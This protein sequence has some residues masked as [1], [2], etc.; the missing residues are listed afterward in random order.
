[1]LS[2]YFQWW[3]LSKSI[4]QS[5]TLTP[6][7]SHFVKELPNGIDGP[8]LTILDKHKNLTNQYEIW[9]ILGFIAERV[10]YFSFWK[11]RTSLPFDWNPIN[12]LHLQY[13]GCPGCAYESFQTQMLDWGRSP[14]LIFCVSASLEAHNSLHLSPWNICS[15]F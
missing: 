1:M 6:N 10:N 13:N 9:L 12:F 15:I 4:D 3:G 14:F 11:Y 7:A 5:N 2:I 8:L